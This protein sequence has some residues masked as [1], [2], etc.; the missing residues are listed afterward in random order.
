MCA[1]SREIYYDFL[2]SIFDS[3]NINFYLYF[4]Y[5]Y[6]NYL[7]NKEKVLLRY[8]GKN[9]LENI[10]NNEKYCLKINDRKYLIQKIEN[11][12]IIFRNTNNHD[13]VTALE[14][15]KLASQEE[16]Q[17]RECI[18]L[19]IQYKKKKKIKKNKKKKKNN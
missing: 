3:K 12:K 16:L 11:K 2:L 18:I 5:H 4:S 10:I 15:S 14:A 9:L 7:T 13:V 17:N 6:I 1:S 19:K 8:R